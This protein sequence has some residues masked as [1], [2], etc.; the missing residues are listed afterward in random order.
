MLTIEQRLASA[1]AHQQ[2]GRLAE[3]EAL[4]RGIL[5]EAPTHPHAL[6]LLGVLSYQAGRHQEAL[7]L[8][9]E[10]LLVQGPHPV[11]HSN[12][13]AVYLALGLLV[14]AE[15]HSREAIRLRPDYADAWSNL[16]VALRRKGQHDEAAQAFQQAL[17]LNPNHP[18]ARRQLPLLPQQTG[19]H[20]E[21][22]ARLQHAI[23]LDPRNAQAHNGLAV[24]LL[25][26]GQVAAAVRHLREAIRLRP[27]FAEA[28]LNLGVA[29]QSLDR[30]EEAMRCYREALRL[31]P[32]DLR[33]RTNLAGALQ[34]EGRIDE[35]RAELRQTLQADPNNS[36]AIYQLAEMTVTGHYQFDEGELR[37]LGELAGAADLPID[38]A[39]RISYAL[40][41]VF[42][43]A[44]D[45]DQAFALC[46]RGNELRKEINRH[47]GIVYDPDAQRA[48][49]D[50]QVAFFTPAWF[51]HVR[52]FGS[53][54]ELPV[55]I[56]G[57]PRSGTTLAEQILASHPPVYGAGELREME[58]LADDLPRR[59]GAT[60]GFP[61][62]L[63]RLD[64]TTARGLAEEHLRHLRQPGRA[65]PRI[66]DKAPLNF[67]Y[68][69]LIRMLFPRARIIHCRRD[70][71][72]TC[73]SCYFR[74]FADAFPFARDLRSLGHFYRQYERL[75]AHWARV[76]PGPSF[77]LPYEE[78]TANQEEVSRR[79]VAFCGLEW[80]ERC[81][82]FHDTRRTVRTASALQVRRPMYRSSVGRWRRYEAHLGPLLE[83]LRGE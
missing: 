61:E 58:L 49:V 17:R 14:E 43:Q 12:L 67:R 81:L 66:V 3:A 68:L 73:L 21:A 31:G 60:E 40:A 69:G 76:L 6:H 8:I 41:R 55:F 74:N 5:E 75:M 18:E 38:D 24:V 77:E 64:A 50:R 28:H 2:A 53:D 72:D 13:A 52:D 23:R 63:A 62:C 42:D 33:A 54:S 1:V 15:G 16:G 35:A 56:V 22:L 78:L 27:D 9:Q 4:Y 47:L 7:R 29:Y 44:A 26:V 20:A 19:P 46:R 48:L 80:D 30:T 10:A 34:A 70:P 11:F 83:A 79:L 39:C 45:Y 51:E 65:A 57:M 25:S 71:I 32:S 59:L 37:R 82:R 36:Q